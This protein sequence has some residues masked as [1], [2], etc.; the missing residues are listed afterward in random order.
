MAKVTS[1]GHGAFCW[2]EL[3]TSDPTAAA[4]F[5]SELFG[6]KTKTQTGE[7]GSYTMAEIDGE[8]VCG[9]TAMQKQMA[10]QG[11]PPHWTSYVSVDS[12]D[13]AAQRAGE[14]GAKVLAPPFDVLEVGRM[15]VIQDPT[16]AALALWQAKQHIGATVT[17]VPGTLTWN[18]LQTRDIDRAKAFFPALFGWTASGESHY[19]EWLPKGASKPTGGMIAIDASWGPVPPSWMVYFA[20]DDVDAS[21]ARAK[22]LG[23][24]V[25]VSEDLPKVGRFAVLQDP[26]G[27]TFSVFKRSS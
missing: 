23:A 18:E 8:S 3:A 17:G 7:W 14:L 27:A 10:A 15:A 20:S 13:A 12:V 16:G 5:Y 26:Q 21:I 1:Y 22:N 6:W 19:T 4:V 2:V 9:I 24:K 11:V 25:L